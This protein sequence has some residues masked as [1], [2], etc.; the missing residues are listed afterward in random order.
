MRLL[1]HRGDRTAGPENS[2]RSVV[3]A[4]RRADGAEV[5]VLVTADGRAALRHDDRL[6]S[7]YPV[8]DLPLAEVRR[9]LR[10]DADTLPEVGEVLT[11][12]AGVGSPACRLNLEL[13][14]PGAARALRPHAGRFDRVVFTSFFATEV[15]DAAALYPSVPSGYLVAQAPVGHVPAGAAFLSV[16]HPLLAAVRA[17]HPTS[18]L[19]AWTVNDEVAAR[20]AV[21]MG[22]AAL[23]GDDPAAIRTWIST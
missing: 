23:I 17:S 13:K 19:W 5:D 7:G 4:F 2:L 16:R 15:L 10:A 12:I 8:R 1:A 11:A 22:C 21:A 20:T 3:A 18:P 14:V 6:P 9:L